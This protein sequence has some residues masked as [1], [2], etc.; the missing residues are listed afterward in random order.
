MDIDD[1]Y[2]AGF[3]DADGYVAMDAS[4]VP[5]V[6]FTNADI[7]ILVDIKTS[8]G[9]KLRTKKS[10]FEN[11]NDS[12]SLELYSR[13]AYNALVRLLP[14]MRHSKKVIRSSL[15]VTHYLNCT[16]RNGKYNSDQR[17]LKSWL[18]NEVRNIIM[19]GKGAYENS[20]NI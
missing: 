6:V 10:K 3:L 15:I 11:H 19:R 14:Y 2:V 8:F 18:T 4:G 20:V 13:Q 16:P 5:C 9:G 1:R 17:I 12:H 7:Q